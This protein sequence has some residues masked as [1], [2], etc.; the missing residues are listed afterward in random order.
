[1]ANTN[2][3]AL[4]PEFWFASFDS[5]DIGIYNL[6]Q[7]VSR[8]VEPLLAKAGDTVNVPLTP[9]MDEAED[10]TPGDVITAQGITQETA[11]VV[12]NQSKKKTIGLTGKELSLAPYDLIET[13]GVPMAKSILKAVNNYLYQTLMP[14]RYFTDC[15]SSFDEDKVV[16]LKTALDKAE[17]GKANRRLVA[18]TDD[19]G[20]MLKLDAFQHVDKSGDQNAMVEGLVKRKFGFDIYENHIIDTYTPADL[21]GAVHTDGGLTGGTSLVVDGFNDDARPI[22]PGDIFTIATETGTPQHTVVST[23]KSS[24]DTIGI[25]FTPP[26]AGAVS[27]GDA[28]TVVPSR[29]ILGFVPA[30]VAFAARTYAPLPNVRTAVIRYLDL[31]IRIVVW[32]DSSTLNVN[33]QYDILYGAKMVNPKRVARL[34][35]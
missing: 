8:D 20:A 33:V 28:I 25:V 9:D 15:R 7:M 1:M 34:L 29:S 18:G 6:Q 19:I 26:L 3:D 12:L 22:R 31:P 30:A 16:D 32:V 2:M 10:W 35:R 23:T 17:V 5:L 11:P 13:Y 21:S 27:D 4:Y 14:T 24:G